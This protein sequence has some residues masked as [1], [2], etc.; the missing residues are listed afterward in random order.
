MDPVQISRA[1][2]AG[3]SGITLRYG[4]NSKETT[5]ALVD[6][7]FGLGMEPVVQVGGCGVFSRGKRHVWGIDSLFF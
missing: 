6:V 4:L 7:A 5:Q 2:L 3:A 1:K